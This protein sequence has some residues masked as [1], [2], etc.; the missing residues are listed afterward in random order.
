MLFLRSL[1]FNIGS[2]IMLIVIILS[3]LLVFFLPF[4]I[5]YEIISKWAIFSVWWLKIT[6]NVSFEIK[7][8]ENIP[9]EPCVV[10][11]NHQ[12][13][14]DT[15]V[16]QTFLPHQTW[17]LKKQLLLIPVFGWGLALLRP[18]TI[19]R[20]DKFSAI[21]K[22]TKQGIARIKDKIWVIIY[23]EGTRQPD[24]KLAKYQSGGIAIAQKSGAKIL[25]IYH[26]AGKF[27]AKGKF[28]KK[29]GKI[30]ITIGKAVDTSGLKSKEILNSVESWALNLQ[31]EYAKSNS[32][33]K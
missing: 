24:G 23:P 20:E 2:N 4:K 31:D 7:G 3:A 1:I 12:S 8:R 28:I 27:W 32:I 30:I 19:D 11:S 15:L 26:N 16:F 9:N 6:C 22:V 13:T 25:P 10:M 18:I 5:R 33:N 14:W 17:V 29:P 21:R